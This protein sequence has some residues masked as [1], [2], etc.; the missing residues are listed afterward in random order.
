MFILQLALIALTLA[1]VPLGYVWY[2]KK[3]DGFTQLVCLTAWLTFD[4]II[5]GSFTRLTDSGLG[6][7]DWPGCYGTASPFAAHL[8]IQAAQHMLPHGPVTFKKA[9][10]EMIHR[11]MAMMLGVLL[12]VQLGWACIQR[13][14]L[15]VPLLWPL[16]LLSL[17]I[18]QG[19]FGAWTVTLKLQPL[20]V[21]THLLL[22]LTLLSLL[23]ALASRRLLLVRSSNTPRPTEQSTSTIQQHTTTQNLAAS[24]ASPLMGS[25]KKWRWAIWMGL[26]LLGIQIALGGW[27]SSNYAMLACPDFPTCQG[28]WWPSMHIAEGFYPWRGPHSSGA[29]LGTLS[30]QAQVAIHWIHR[31]MAGVVFVYFCTL[32]LL[33]RKHAPA[34]IKH[35]TY[36]LFSILVL[37]MITGISNVLLPWP[38]W[39][40]LAH[41]AGAA[42]LLVLSF[43]LDSQLAA[44][45]RTGAH[46]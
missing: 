46:A 22:G 4:L 19:A 37:Q 39:T 24:S 29:N 17:I 36:I 14:Q 40:A 16:S 23:S 28:Q 9:W 21:T 30:L 26:I 38:L 32:A 20:V 15:R 45:H 1:L 12:I 6:C 18:L 8:D 42:A 35:T 44:Q 43:F 5:F 33:L 34:T 2:F 3:T 31:V 10:I 41:N 25:Y 11:Y 13:R 27:V 7:P